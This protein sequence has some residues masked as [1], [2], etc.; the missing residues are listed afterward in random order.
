MFDQLLNLVKQQAGPVIFDNP[1][2]PN[3]RNEEAVADVTSSITGGLQQALAGGQ[4]KDV[5]KL[6]GGQGGEIEAN[7]LAG[8][9]SGNAVSSLM[10]KFN[11]NQGQAGSIVS[12]LLPGVLN[13][14]ISKTNDPTDN[15]IDLQGIFSS[16]T[17][18]STNGIDLQGLLGRVTQGGFD[19]DGDGDTD[20]NDVITMVKGGASQ[21]SGAGGVM[22][23]VKG[24]FS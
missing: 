13:N 1:D 10:E 24:L 15:S 20:L 11:L 14:F 22:D 3:E 4:F 2:I 19:K 21:Q 17:G 7:P 9:L 12:N 23:M 6:L 16:L 8:Q 18:G 5:L